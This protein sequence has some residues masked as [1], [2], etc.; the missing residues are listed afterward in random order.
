MLRSLIKQSFSASKDVTNKDPVHVKNAANSQYHKS[1]ESFE[2]HDVEQYVANFKKSFY[3]KQ[4]LE[5]S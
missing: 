5:R 1:M 4:Y 3:D 2:K